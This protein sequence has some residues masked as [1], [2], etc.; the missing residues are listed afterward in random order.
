MERH[1]RN[2]NRWLPVTVA[3]AVGVAGYLIGTQVGMSNAAH[4]GAD[5]VVRLLKEKELVP[6]SVTPPAIAVPDKG[7]AIVGAADDRYYIVHRDG[8]VTWV[9]PDRRE[10][11]YWRRPY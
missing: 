8:T 5:D 10:D 4:A 3:A 1:E 9:Q 6:I 7:W 11:L 2:G